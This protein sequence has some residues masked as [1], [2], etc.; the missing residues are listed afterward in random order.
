MMHAINR[1]IKFSGETIW[2]N[3][4]LSVITVST[5]TLTLISVSVVVGLQ[6]GIDQIVHATEA[7]IDLSIY[8]YPQATDD[9]VQ[10]VVVAVKALPGVTSVDVVTKDAALAQYQQNA[11]DVPEL[12]KPLEAL[13]DNPFGASL[14]IKADSP[15]NYTGVIDELSKPQYKDLIEG[16]Q[17]DYEANQAFI[18]NFTSF[19]DKVRLG[20]V[21]V[22][23]FFALV[24]CL[25]L[26]NTI[27]VAIYTHRDEIAVMKLVGATNRFVRTPFLIEAFFYCFLATILAAGAMFGLVYFGQPYLSQYFGAGEVDLYGYFLRNGIYVFAAEFA[28]IFILSVISSWFAVRKYLRV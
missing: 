21:A 14:T 28:F 10:S 24:A 25:L 17:K 12:L 6:A 7:R 9:Q 5:I 15:N 8:F 16:E 18:Q 27:R 2:R 4:W 19:T 13:G 3:L 11:K 20:A 26:F 23:G 22:S 1:L